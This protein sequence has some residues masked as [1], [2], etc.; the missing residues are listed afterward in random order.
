M[1]VTIILPWIA[2]AAGL[3]WMFRQGEKAKRE[4]L[5]QKKDQE[6]LG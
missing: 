2:F 4:Y 1:T 6:R 5:Q 3:F